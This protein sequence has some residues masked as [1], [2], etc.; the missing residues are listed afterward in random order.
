MG[1]RNLA[2]KKYE[3]NFLTKS[4]S[5]ILKSALKLSL[6]PTIKLGSDFGI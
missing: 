3:K 5:K 2:L 4:D 6:V 1:G